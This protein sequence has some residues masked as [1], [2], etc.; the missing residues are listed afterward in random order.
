MTVKHLLKTRRLYYTLA[1]LLVLGLNINAL[2]QPVYSQVSYIWSRQQSVIEK[3]GRWDIAKYDS[4]VNSVHA[5]LLRTGKVLLIAGSGNNEESFAAKSFRTV[6]WDPATGEFK[7]VATPW[8]AFCA[9]HVFL[10]DGRLLVA[11][12][13]AGYEDLDR[14]PRLEYQ[15]LKDAY[16]FDPITERYD[17]VDAMQFARWYPTLVSLPDGTA[18]AV[19]GLDENGKQS[20]GEAEIFDPATGTWTYRKDLDHVFPT[21][22]SLLLTNDGRLF[23]S[24][25]SQ[26]YAPS[27]ASHQPGF[28]DLKTNQFTRVFGLPEDDRVDT[29]ASVM[30]PPA[31]DQRVMLLGGGENGDSPVAS[32]RTAIIDLD[33]PNPVYQRTASL[34]NKTRYPGVVILPN[35]RVF[36]TGGSSE[37]RNKNV[38][39]AEIFNPKD[40]TFSQAATPRVGR[41]YHSEALLL[42]D[43]RVATFG[44][45]PIDNS[46]EMRIEI[47][48]PAYL[49]Q[50]GARPVIKDGDRQLTRGQTH[51]WAIDSSKDIKTA[52]LMRPSSV[53]HV[54]DVEQRSIDL[55]FTATAT[56]INVQIPANENLVPPGWYMAF[57]TDKKDV[58]SVAFWVHVN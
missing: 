28:W 29:S 12:G 42:P 18:L 2:V 35:D 7:D 37:Y 48:S 43:G 56:G 58:P 21:Y 39:N 17:K 49:F 23:Y 40:N 15:G 45:N 8:D 27:E 26:G 9:G 34:Q 52:K 33:S 53:T 22:P 4:P 25:S 30:L 13:T 6:I 38:F 10:P 54:T 47:Y 44:S 36:V 20:S 57:V 31:Q 1:I 3:Y 32:S 50:K 19:A 11:G 51:G 55:P 24:G 16:I 5:A 46:W 14:I 41:N